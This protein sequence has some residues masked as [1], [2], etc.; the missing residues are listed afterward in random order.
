MKLKKLEKKIERAYFELNLL[1]ALLT[2]A[3]SITKSSNES[4]VAAFDALRVLI[5]MSVK[6]IA[7][8]QAFTDVPKAVVR[9]EKD[10][11]IGV[12]ESFIADIEGELDKMEKKHT[13]MK[14]MEKVIDN[15]RR[16][17]RRYRLG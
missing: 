6:T 14:E 7:I 17:D 13:T 9:A 15:W 5:A 11:I 16:H 12:L 2:M 3:K 10:T 8:P 4:V 1:V